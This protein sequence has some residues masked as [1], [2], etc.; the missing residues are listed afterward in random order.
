MHKSNNNPVM[1]DKPEQTILFTLQTYKSAIIDLYVQQKGLHMN[2]YEHPGQL[3]E[4][5][6][7]MVQYKRGQD[8]Y[9]AEVMGP[10]LMG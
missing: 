9:M 4:V 2:R 7:L 8:R 6:S 1:I 3:P 10:Y 5:K